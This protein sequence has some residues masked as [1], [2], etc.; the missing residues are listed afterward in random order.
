M[1]DTAPLLGDTTDVSQSSAVVVLSTLV[2]EGR[3]L[4]ER[5][6]YL[7]Q[8]FKELYNRVLVV[9]RRDNFLL[10]R[11]R[12]L[13]KELDSQR[14]Q[15][16]ARG[17]NAVEDDAEIQRLKKLL[18]EAEKELS[19]AQERESILQVEVLEFDRKKH[20]MLLEREDALAAEEARL[21][22]RME[23]I[24]AE[25][26]ALGKEVEELTMEMGNI[27]SKRDEILLQE[28]ECKE[29]L[30]HWNTI[31]VE[32]TKQFSNVEKAPERALR[33]TE[34]V[35]KTYEAAQMEMNSL[36]E[37]LQVQSDTI[38][39]LELKQNT[40]STDYAQA[41]ANLQKIK[42]QLDSKR[43]MLATLNT[44]LEMELEARQGYQQRIAQLEQLIKSTS[45]AQDKEAGDLE[46]VRR[47]KERVAMEYM[48]LEHTVSNIV[49]GK[50]AIKESI[51]NAK[52]KMEQVQAKRKKNLQRLEETQR[53]LEQRNRG[54]LKEQGR[55]QEFVAKAASV[56][57]DVA[58]IKCELAGR[59]SQEELKRRET[60]ALIIR[61]Q[62]LNW[63]CAKE[64]SRIAMGKNELRMKGMYVNDVRRRKE[65]LEQRL[66]NMIE[67]FQKIKAER[68]HKAA[69]I[70]AITQKMTEMSEKK[71]ILENELVVLCRESSLKETELA[72]KKR[73]VE[74]LRQLCKNLRMEKN[75]HRKSLE[76]VCD[77]E[78]NVKG[79]VRR[80]NAQIVGLE[81]E[82]DD[83]KHRYHDVIESRNY[84]GVQLFDRNDELCVLYERVNAQE[85]VIRDGV[86]MN[87]ARDEEIRTLRIKLADLY[88][89]VEVVRKSAPKIK[90]LEE[91]LEQ[92][93]E[94]ID[95]ERWKVEVL[96]NDLTNPNNPHR[97][98]LIKR[99]TAGREFS[100][101]TEN[102]VQPV[103]GATQA[104]VLTP[105][106]RS[107]VDGPSDEFLHLQQRCQEL[108]E[109][110]NAINERIREKDLILEE[111][112]ELSSRLGDQAKTGCEFTLA[113]AKQVNSHHSSIRAKTRQMMATVSE[114]SVFQASAIQLQQDV[115]RLECLVEEAER[116]MEQGEAPFIEAEERYVREMEAKQRHASMLRRRKEAEAEL[117]AASTGLVTKAEQR[118]NAYIPD[119]DL[120]FPR[121][122]GALVPFKPTPT[123]QSSRF[124]RGQVEGYQSRE[125]QPRLGNSKMPVDRVSSRRVHTFKGPNHLSVTH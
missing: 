49:R 6:D 106:I 17:N 124:Y 47:E 4:E 91:Q 89:E 86:L 20:T 68:S 40:R 94:Y 16:V 31:M 5:S 81:V 76:K 24:R 36:D 114:L 79:Q 63:A 22:P 102:T 59:A 44:S 32:A 107:G 15:I 117:T 120:G 100:T 58:A 71:T 78:R 45:I 82:M 64:K 99:T 92:M 112:T 122:Y 85:K 53:E 90:E 111:V 65:E 62:E 67:T 110:V 113:L 56:Q 19:D 125:T 105:R 52:K 103:K 2:E 35:I 46:H 84:A 75:R 101:E 39:K 12:Q 33:Q 21:L 61:R 41:L 13:R 28:A 83:V 87:N 50:D 73:Q 109:R 123:P 98:R 1:T 37:R 88:R 26:T 48:E 42:A 23:A 116:L 25:M 60:H 34:L 9:Y 7:K 70:Q 93:T 97:W 30:T 119:S 108:E 55:E 57:E 72:K 96:E 74:E 18:V 43:T 104:S 69:Q 118:P 14:E 66:T 3:L 115:Q 121:P 8:K 10:K 51:A 27:G 80:V 95:D 54:F 38:A 11:A 77:D 29:Q